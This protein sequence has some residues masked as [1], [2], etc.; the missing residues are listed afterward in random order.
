MMK[1]IIVAVLVLCVVA[2]QMES[3]EPS[4]ADCI[5]A[6]TTG[7]VQPNGKCSFILSLSKTFRNLFR[8]GHRVDTKPKRKTRFILLLMS[9]SCSDAARFMQRCEIKCQIKC[10]PGK[11]NWRSFSPCYFTLWL[12]SQCSLVWIR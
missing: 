7:C 3:V 11:A 1:K 12:I 10:D 5:D 9:Y 6:C 4:A 8:S 2:S